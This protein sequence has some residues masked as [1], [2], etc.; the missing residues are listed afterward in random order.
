MTSYKPLV[1]GIEHRMKYLDDVVMILKQQHLSK[2]K[3]MLEISSYPIPQK[4]W[5]LNREFYDFFNGLGMYIKA[6]RGIIVPGDSEELIDNA[7]QK[8]DEIRHLFYT[9]FSSEWLPAIEKIDNA[10]R[11]PYFLAVT[12]KENPD[13]IILHKNHAKYIN[14][15][16]SCEY[17]PVPNLKNGLG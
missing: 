13:I 9:K 2:K 17:I 1:I 5:K 4:Y 15:N 11:N 14:E 16:I 3:V 6:C 7:V 12:L 8:R 10:E